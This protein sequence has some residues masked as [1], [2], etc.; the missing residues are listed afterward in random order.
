MQHFDIIHTHI[1]KICKTYKTYSCI[2]IDPL[3]LL[4]KF[5]IVYWCLHLDGFTLQCTLKR[6][7]FVIVRR[8]K[9]IFKK[10]FVSNNNRLPLVKILGSSKGYLWSVLRSCHFVG[11]PKYNFKFMKCKSHHIEKTFTWYC[12]H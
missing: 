7:P 1:K 12:I 6:L 8:N 9:R 2:N 11:V 4:L 3:K 10:T 5:Y